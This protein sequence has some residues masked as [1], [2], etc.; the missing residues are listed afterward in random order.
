MQILGSLE[1]A[2]GDTSKAMDDYQ[3][4]LKID[5]NDGS[6]ANNLAY[7]TVDTGG[8]VDV[9][10]SLAQTARRIMP[11]SPQT[12]DTLAWVYYHK[13]NYGAARDLLESALR[14]SPDDP[15]MH[16]H[17]GMTY[18]A[19]NDKSDA[20]TQLKKAVTLAPNDKAGKDAAAQLSKL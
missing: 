2:K 15:T 18:A 12:A 7:L 9:A 6:A 13:Q 5:P 16:Y 11:D 17:L 19:L 20:Q 14:T 10:L 4:A 1:E 8:N 3:K